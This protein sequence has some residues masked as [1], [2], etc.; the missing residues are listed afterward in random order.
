MLHI[1]VRTRSNVS[2][3]LPH[4]LYWQISHRHVELIYCSTAFFHPS[5]RIK[6]ISTVTPD[7]LIPHH[8]A[9]GCYV[10]H[11]FENLSFEEHAK[12]NVLRVY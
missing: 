7:C 9:G 11:D 4:P 2:C 8:G 10:S 3:Q 6:G 12:G 1:R 5:I